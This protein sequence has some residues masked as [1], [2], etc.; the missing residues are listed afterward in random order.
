MSHLIRVALIVLIF[1]LPGFSEDAVKPDKLA[2]ICGTWVRMQT[3]A[4]GTQISLM[5]LIT[6]THFAVFQQ[7]LAKTKSDTFQAHSGQYAIRDGS[8]LET[9][10]FSSNPKTLGQTGKCRVEVRGD[11]LLQTWTLEDGSDTIE[12]WDRLRTGTKEDTA[13]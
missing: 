9:Y 12:E 2:S 4:D 11:K 7:D 8:M 5:K 10:G 3:L 1:S 6:P 13:E